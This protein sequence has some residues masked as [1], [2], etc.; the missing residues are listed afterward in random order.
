MADLMIIKKSLLGG[1]FGRG[2]CIREMKLNK[3]KIGKADIRIY[4]N[5]PSEKSIGI[6]YNESYLDS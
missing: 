1:T 4:E 2:F 3:K 5:L 6:D